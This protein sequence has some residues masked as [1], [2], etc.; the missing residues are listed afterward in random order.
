MP[1]TLKHHL[2]FVRE[3]DADVRAVEL[4]LDDQGLVGDESSRL[5]FAEVLV[6]VSPRGPEEVGSPWVLHEVAV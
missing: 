2:G 5:E 4:L 3:V 1:P 6:V